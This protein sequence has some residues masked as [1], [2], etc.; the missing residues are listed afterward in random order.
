MNKME[1]RKFIKALVIS[2]A[3]LFAFP[4]R[5]TSTIFAAPSKAKVVKIRNPN[6]RNSKGDI[7]KLEINRTIYEAL[8]ILSES[9]SGEELLQKLI[10]PKDVV[11][12]KV[13]AYLGEANNATKPEIAYGLADFLIK[14]GVP[15]NQIIIWDRTADELE[16]A[17]YVINDK[18]TDVRCIATNTKRVQRLS[19]PMAG[20]DDKTISI[21]SATT[22]VSNIVSKL[23]TVLINMPSI[24]TFKFKE[25]TGVSGAIMNMYGAIEIND[26]NSK[27]LYEN[28]CNPGAAEI[29]NIKDIKN[30]TRLVICDAI[31]P[32]YNGGPSDDSRYHW[33]YNGIIAGLD[34]VAVDIVAQESIQEYRDKVLP[35]APKLRS[36]YL[37]TC[38]GSKYRLGIVDI[39]QIEVIE[40]E[41]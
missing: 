8:R 33:N 24:K 16:Q 5:F 39:K 10:N 4:F 23:C 40:K 3:G 19:K 7:N 6:M 37:E 35:D 13:S 11:G 21:G 17:G 22:R 41:I 29:Y 20:F 18:K 25:Y 38:A 27:V 9:S 14:I 15:D 2:G 30:K 26:G 1:R 32:L 12:I 31:Y 36:D 34:P 28:D